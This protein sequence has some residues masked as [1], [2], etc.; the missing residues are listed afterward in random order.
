MLSSECWVCHTLKAS[1]FFSHPTMHYSDSSVSLICFIC[2]SKKMVEMTG[3]LLSSYGLWLAS[4]IHVVISSLPLWGCDSCLPTWL[5]LLAG[6]MLCF[7]Q[8][9]F[10]RFNHPEEALRMKSMLPGGLS[11]PSSHPTGKKP[12]FKKIIIIINNPDWTCLLI[13]L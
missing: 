5:S 3:V 4:L 2:K 10:F 11:N 6:C 1:C 7:G 13:Q 12:F 9:A 8:S